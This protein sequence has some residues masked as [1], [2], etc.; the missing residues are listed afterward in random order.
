MANVQIADKTEKC[1]I[2]GICQAPC[3]RSRC[4][5]LQGLCRPMY[6]CASTILTLAAMLAAPSPWHALVLQ[7]LEVADMRGGT[8]F[9]AVSVQ[10]FNVLGRDPHGL[11]NNG[12]LSFLTLSPTPVLVLAE[13][14]VGRVPIRLDPA[15]PDGLVQAR[16]FSPWEL[17]ASREETPPPAS[18]SDGGNN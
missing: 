16:V 3:F 18:D 6:D 17:L 15:G 7:F 1:S 13:V 5:S 4:A 11:S 14:L 12:G 9:A 8:A 2:A 10:W